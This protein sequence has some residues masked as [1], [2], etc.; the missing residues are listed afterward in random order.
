MNA[1]KAREITLK[2]RLKL[3]EVLTFIKAMAE[4]GNNFASFEPTRIFEPEQMKKYLESEGYGVDISPTAFR[5]T[6]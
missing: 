3:P 4:S 5:I 1:E 2:A 6:W